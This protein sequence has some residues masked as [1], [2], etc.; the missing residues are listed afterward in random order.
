MSVQNPLDPTEVVTAFPEYDIDPVVLGDG[1]MKSAFRIL[2]DEQL[3]LKIV[4]E[5][6]T[7][8]A[9]EGKVSISERVRREIESMQKIKHSRIVPII[10]GP[11]LRLISGKL[12]VWYTEP[13]FEGGSLA[14]R[15]SE[16]WTES[17]CLDL[18]NG[19]V[20]AAEALAEYNI[21]HR[22][23]KPSNILFDIDNIPVLID[24]GIAYFQ[25]LT[26]LTDNWGPSPRTPA[27][28]A[29]EQ[30]DI[31]RNIAIDFRTDLFLIGIVVFESLTGVHP[32]NPGDSEGYL[33]RLFTGTWSTEATDLLY[34][35]KPSY[36]FKQILKRLLD[37]SM[38]R[39]YRTFEHLRTAIRDL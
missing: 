11:D 6:L 27:Y 20:D 4:R 2:G 37:P 36:K 1:G 7:D 18:L 38:S 10:S 23:I 14:D 34:R 31:R 26:P 33:K 28:A 5:P 30:F 32:Y 12:H 24:L 21:V 39:R 8:D 15:L 19:L 35:A 25:D 3:V 9:M 16:P 13:L 22:D 17:K 29:P